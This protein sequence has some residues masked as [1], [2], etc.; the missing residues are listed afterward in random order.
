MLNLN[1]GGVMQMVLLQITSEGH[2]VDVSAISYSKELDVALRCITKGHSVLL[3]RKAAEVFAVHQSSVLD[4]D[5]KQVMIIS[6]D[7]TFT[8]L[9]NVEADE[10]QEFPSICYNSLFETVAAACLYAT[11][12]GLEFVHSKQLIEQQ[13]PIMF[14]VG[15]YKT[16]SA[17][18]HQI[19]KVV[20][21]EIGPGQKVLNSG[22][23]LDWQFKA[24]E[25]TA[26]P[27]ALE[28]KNIS[29]SVL[30]KV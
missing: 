16:M 5:D 4:N 12:N 6:D 11:K 14:V 8:A 28:L 1:N 2:A 7:D 13:N 24:E 25:H 10:G 22:I 17:L 3:S 23:T 15:G 19:D 29:L 18:V 26:H 9:Y 21:I 20:R 30:T 27:K